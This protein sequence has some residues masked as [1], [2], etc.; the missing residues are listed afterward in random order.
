[1]SSVSRAAA[2]SG[3]IQH[4]GT[5]RH[6]RTI[7]QVFRPPLKKRRNKEPLVSAPS[8]KFF[9]R[10]IDRH[11]KPPSRTYC[12]K[13]ASNVLH[14]YSLAV[15]L[16]VKIRDAEWPCGTVKVPLTAD[17]W[18]SLLQSA[19]RTIGAQTGASL[20]KTAMGSG[21]QPSAKTGL[22]AMDLGSRPLNAF[23]GAGEGNR[24]LVTCLG[25]KS[26]AI[27]LH[28]RTGIFGNTVRKTVLILRPAA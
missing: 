4:V 3:S 6:A 10:R 15:Q 14:G 1:M 26:S 21:Q 8:L 11:R 28:P 2:W 5:S 17:V 27:E 18:P 22:I 9:L 19:H 24:T 7:N 13:S 16:W 23:F 25:S 20:P 12:P